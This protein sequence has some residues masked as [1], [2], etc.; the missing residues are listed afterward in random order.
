M[1]NGGILPASDD[2]SSDDGSPDSIDV[3][4]EISDAEDEI[5]TNTVLITTPIITLLRIA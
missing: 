1:E 5:A 2:D 3:L 4:T